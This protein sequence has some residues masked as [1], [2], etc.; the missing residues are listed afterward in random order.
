MHATLGFLRT[1]RWLLIIKAVGISYRFSP[2]LSD[3]IGEVTG[4][5][6][7]LL[8]AVADADRREAG[9]EPPCVTHANS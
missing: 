8:S 1:I 4:L 6:G 2:R 9:S 3:L 7:A 5:N